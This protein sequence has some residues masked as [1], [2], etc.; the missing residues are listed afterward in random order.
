[1]RCP[2]APTSTAAVAEALSH[3]LSIYLSR[4]R[5]FFVLFY[6]IPRTECVNLDEFDSART[7]TLIPPDGE[8]VGEWVGRWDTD[9]LRVT[10][11]TIVEEGAD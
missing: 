8:F 6:F 9:Y 7:L 4:S 5:S 2:D 11:R 1:M 10:H 3:I